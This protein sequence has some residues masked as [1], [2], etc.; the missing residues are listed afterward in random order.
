MFNPKVSVGA[1]IKRP[2]ELKD[3]SLTSVLDGIESG[4]NSKALIERV[5]IGEADK[6]LLPYICFSGTFTYR[7]EESLVS[8]SS[9][10]VLDFDEKHLKGSTPEEFKAKL[11]EDPFIYAVFIS[12][13]GNGV[14]ALVRIQDAN[15]HRD[16]FRALDSKYGLD[17]SG[18]DPSRAC[19]VSYDP[20]IYINPQAFVFSD[21]L[22]EKE[23]KK[24]EPTPNGVRGVWK[25]S[26]YECMDVPTR[27]IARS[28]HG[29]KHHVLAKAA[30]LT[31]GFVASG[32]IDGKIAKGILEHEIS[33]KEGVKDLKSAYRTIHE[34]M[35]DGFK[36]PATLF[37]RKSKQIINEFGE[38]IFSFLVTPD[39]VMTELLSRRDNLMQRTWSTG[40]KELDKH[41]LWKKNKLVV[42]LGHDKVGK[43][44]K[45]LNLLMANAVNHGWRFIIYAIENT[46]EDI[47]QELIELVIGKRMDST[48]DPSKDKW[49]MTN[50]EFSFAVDFVNEHF[51]IIDPNSGFSI[52]ELLAKCAELLETKSYQ[53]LLID[54]FNALSQKST[55]SY[56]DFIQ[57]SNKLRIF[58][59][60]YC[61]IFLNIHTKTEAKKKS[62][63]NGKRPVPE[64]YDGEFGSNWANKCDTFLVTHRDGQVQT[65][66]SER[67]VT[68]IFVESERNT[69][70]GTQPHTRFDD[71]FIDGFR[72]RY[73]NYKFLD[74]GANNPLFESPF[75][76][77]KVSYE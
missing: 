8:H 37:D 43:T 60:D 76:G 47:Y 11:T 20:D 17:E 41:F 67:F 74:E 59:R 23:S 75:N 52:D 26:K 34:C 15:R 50:E 73:S 62:K 44:L 77:N 25:Q 38:T 13:S 33:K 55:Y 28:D 29:E 51:K 48:G 12:P 5:R 24:I 68:T 61:G 57:D 66:D 6:N 4:G 71:P 31:G 65:P 58:T 72:M 9:L 36:D 40:S 19:Y 2:S 46:E 32:L 42:N 64:R 35:S 56:N 63:V 7:N 49:Q 21:L 53:Y 30:Y 69:K 18:S 3:V 54:P 45:S 70:L 22:K 39:D 1:S 10:I 14:K 16:H 27:M